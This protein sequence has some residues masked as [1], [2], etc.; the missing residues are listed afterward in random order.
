MTKK[1][2][3]NK[4]KKTRKMKKIILPKHKKDGGTVLGSGSE[5]CVVDSFSCGDYS[6]Q[7]GY[8]AKIMKKE[9][10]DEYDKIH[11]ILI[12]VDPNE[13]RFA[14]YHVK[15]DY[16]CSLSSPTDIFDCEK[17]LKSS[18]NTERIHMT[19]LLLPIQDTRKL[20]K[21]QYRYLR[22]SLEILRNIIGNGRPGHPQNHAPR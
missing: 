18:L 5:G 13:E 8:V 10:I 3:K 19:K 20:T 22:K 15:R 17:L 14:M 1:S 9:R 4:M 11:E 16:E 7:N 12:E 6:I 21:I 2:N